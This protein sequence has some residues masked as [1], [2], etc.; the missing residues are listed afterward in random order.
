M[1]GSSSSAPSRTSPSL[2]AGVGIGLLATATFGTSGVAARPLL[3]T[4]WS[5]G[6]LVLTRI[7]VAALILLGPGIWGMRGQWG[8]LRK[9]AGLLIV[10]G[11]VAV[12]GA[13]LCYFNAVAHLSV[14]VAL[15][16]EYS[17]ILLVVGWHWARTGVRPRNLTLIGTAVAIIGLFLVLD[18]TGG[19]VISTVGVL[20]GAGA[21]C[22]LAT[23]FVIAERTEDGVPALT[24]VS[25]GM[26]VGG[27]ALGLAGLSGILPLT[28]SQQDVVIGG[29][30]MSWMVPAAWLAVMTAAFAYLVGVAATRILGST[31]SSFLGLTE[32]LFAIVFAWLLLGEVPAPIQL[33][34]G[35]L[36][37]AGV[38]LVRIGDLRAVP[39]IADLTT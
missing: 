34:G 1:S 32:V 2:A 5:P 28:A 37:L 10:F 23:F 38:V 9:K 29:A 6:A 3:N 7:G 17:G 21:A 20:W 13:Q 36:V 19:V 30:T 11:V 27:T 25:V 4:G 24:L 26:V 12:A 8:L 14:G 16:L 22:C 33:A 15:L 35:A 31:L 39:A 18:I